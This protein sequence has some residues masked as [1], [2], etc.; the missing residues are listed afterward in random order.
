M[1]AH[2][3]RLVTAALA[4]EPAA[5]RAIEEAVRTAAGSAARKLG[6]RARADE[7]AQRVA[8]K[9]WLGREGGTP[10]L[11]TYTGEVPLL[12]WLKVIAYREGV[13]L[14][15]HRE[16]PSDDALIDR[17]V[18]SAE[19]ELAMLKRA[20]LAAF[21][22]AFAEALREL[23]MHDR[24]LLR[25]HHLDGLTIDGLATLHGVHRATAARWLAQVRDQ[26]MRATRSALARALD[27][28]VD[29][30]E[31]LTLISSQLEA[32]LSRQLRTP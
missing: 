32:S 9:L 28:E 31:V 15:R 3:L 12:A 21:K 26:L 14:L 29:L 20:Y 2:D 7:I 4:R 24:D 16:V 1:S 11:P 27:G 18:G 30:A 22:Q 8:E 10:I 23:S 5:E 25:R 13:D 17:I 6:D 19:P